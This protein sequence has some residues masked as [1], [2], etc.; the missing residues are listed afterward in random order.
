MSF[1]CCVYYNVIVAYALYYLLISLPFKLP[2]GFDTVL[3]YDSRSSFCNQTSEYWKGND[4]RASSCAEYFYNT[5]VL[6]ES[7]DLY[8]E[9]ADRFSNGLGIFNWPLFLL[10][11]GSDRKS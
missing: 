2:F 4:T 5:Q 7:E 6:K 10:L 9:G 8:V 3:P 11:R 1:F